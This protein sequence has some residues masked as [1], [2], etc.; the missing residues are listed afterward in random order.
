MNLT[1][2]KSNNGILCILSRLFPFYVLLFLMAAPVVGESQSWSYSAVSPHLYHKTGHAEGDGWAATPGKDRSDFLIFGPY[3]TNIPAG[4]NVALFRLKINRNT[5][6]N[7]YVA[8]IDVV[9]DMGN[10]TLAKR[11]LWRNSFAVGNAYQNF[12]LIFN[13]RRGQKL[14]FRTYWYGSVYVKEKSVTI[15]HGAWA[16]LQAGEIMA[17]EYERSAARD[18]RRDKELRKAFV[19]FPLVTAATNDKG[20]L[21]FQTIYLKHSVKIERADYYGF[22]FKVPRQNDNKD[23]VWAFVSPEDMEGWYILPATGGMNGFRNY[24]YRSKYDYPD[25]DA[26]LPAT[27]RKLILQSLPGDD[28]GDGKNYLI[29]W[30]LNRNKPIRISL[31]FAFAHLSANS[32]EGIE[33]ALDLPPHPTEGPLSPPI[34][35]PANHHTYVLLRA[36]TWKESEKEAEAM[37]GHLATVRNQAEENW[38]FKTFGHYNGAQRLLWIGLN[39]CGKTTKFRWSSGAP[40]TYTDWAKGEPNDAGHGEDYVTILYPNHDQANKWMDWR[41]DRR[42]DP[43]GLPI[44][45]VVEIITNAAN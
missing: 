5:G 10:H 1:K 24:F 6:P 36:A 7:D 25:A 38:I 2:G 12:A 27:G 21:A 3:T 22:R 35:N 20:R 34:V 16:M 30:S 9:S 42:L 11:Y 28:L 45:G 15:K 39:D 26:L 41:N 14:E 33:K 23:F 44:N 40:V 32:T 8:R 43:I 13:S 4:E 29:W 37:G 18:S 17:K 31:K 19:Q